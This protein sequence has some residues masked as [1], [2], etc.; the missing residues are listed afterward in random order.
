MQIAGKHI[1]FAVMIFL[2]LGFSIDAV[3]GESGGLPGAKINLL[4]GP[5]PSIDGKLDEPCWK[6]AAVLKDFVVSSKET[7][8]TPSINKTEVYLLRSDRVFYIGAR[9]FD[10]DMKTISS[11]DWFEVFVADRNLLVYYHF[12]VHPSGN[13]NQDGSP[14]VFTGVAGVPFWH[15]KVSLHEDHW[16]VEMAIPFF[17]FSSEYMSD[18]L[19]RFNICRE[20]YSEPKENSQWSNTGG[21]FHV[22]DL[23][24]NITGM[25]GVDFTPSVDVAASVKMQDVS[26]IALPDYMILNRSYY[27]NESE[28]VCRIC[29]NEE[30]TGRLTVPV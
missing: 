11:N 14:G 21:Y 1:F 12:W 16:Q 23:F 24:G 10:A 19:W 17:N 18:D 8:R 3:A 22:P 20:K 2:S 6:Q 28:A 26:R 25:A 7:A 29:L 27:T 13:I 5:P 15:G 4:S 30:T 9:C